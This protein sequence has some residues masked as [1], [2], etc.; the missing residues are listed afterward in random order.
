MP[1]VFTFDIRGAQP[2][3]HNRIQSF[4][5]RLG[6]QNLGGSSYRYPRLGTQQP[7]EDW[8]NHVIPALMLFRSFILSSGRQLGGFTIDVQSSTGF[9]PNSGYGTAPAQGNATQLYAPSNQAFGEQNLRDWLSGI[10]Y[11][12]QR[13][14]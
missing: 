10:A 12:Y 8:F 13:A 14:G 2:V 6:W 9:D 5:E 3:E 7:V 4:F 11:P 1:V